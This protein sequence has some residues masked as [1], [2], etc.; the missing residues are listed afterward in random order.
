MGIILRDHTRAES[1]RF[2][3]LPA[4]AP[5]GAAA[6]TSAISDLPNGG[7]S[8]HH[9]LRYHLPVASENWRGLVEYGFI[10]VVPGA[11]E[12]RARTAR[13]VMTVM[14]CNRRPGEHEPCGDL[15]VLAPA[16]MRAPS[17][18]AL[19]PA[20]LALADPSL[21][22]ARS[23]SSAVLDFSCPKC[24]LTIR[25]TVRPRVTRCG[26]YSYCTS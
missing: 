11:S 8:L 23:R 7:P 17:P 18:P 26:S 21:G 2:T 19:T 16:R 14:C 4:A 12:S 13:C 24:L 5:G 10:G 6:G 22:L 1:V 15:G 9:D 25:E 3:L 20:P